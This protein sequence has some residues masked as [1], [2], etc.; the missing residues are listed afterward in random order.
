MIPQPIIQPGITAN[1]SMPPGVII[2]EL[3]YD[4]L[5]AAVT[6]LCN[7]FGFTERLR[8]G[9][10]RSQLVFGEAA[11]VA[12][13]RRTKDTPASPGSIRSESPRSEKTHSM[14]VQV[15]DVDRHYEHVKQCGGK[16]TNPPTDYPYGERQ[17]TVEDIAGRTWTFSQSIADI[18]PREWGGVVPHNH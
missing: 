1:R 12:V 3:V 14:M 18:D 15:E 7:T 2:P 8:I 17:Y 6:W 10:H 13:A 11:I 4:D 9:N 5:D 16:I